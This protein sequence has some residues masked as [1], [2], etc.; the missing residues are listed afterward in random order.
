MTS[1]MVARSWSTSGSTGDKLLTGRSE[2]LRDTGLIVLRQRVSDV[3]RRCKKEWEK[4][5]GDYVKRNRDAE[6]D[7]ATAA[8]AAKTRATHLSVTEAPPLSDRKFFVFNAD[9]PGETP[10]L[11]GDRV[12][13]LF[14]GMTEEE[15][16]QHTALEVKEGATKVDAQRLRAELTLM[17]EVG[18]ILVMTRGVN[19]QSVY[20]GEV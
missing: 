20:H 14:K 3:E 8:A 17:E 13:R 7:R 15:R 19:V 12:L 9:S 2:E 16:G 6:R 5:E 18:I 11:S 10:T 1:K 4:L